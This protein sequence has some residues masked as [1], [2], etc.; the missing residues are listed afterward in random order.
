MIEGF[1]P[2]RL[3][4]TLFFSLLLSYMYIHI[5]IPYNRW[6]WRYTSV[7]DIRTVPL[8]AVVNRLPA[9]GQCAGDLMILMVIQKFIF[10]LYQSILTQVMRD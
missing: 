2:Y 9:W 8:Y 7:F 3:V 10:N 4:Y 6:L 1:I 5:S